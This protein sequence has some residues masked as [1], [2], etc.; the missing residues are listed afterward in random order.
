MGFGDV[1]V[2]GGDGAVRIMSKDSG[3]MG[4]FLFGGI[5]RGLS[6]CSLVSEGRVK[7]IMGVASC[8][9]IV[10]VSGALRWGSKSVKVVP[11]LATETLG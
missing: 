11:V 8:P 2:R 9:V 3:A 1:V 5:I 7:V 10:S 6:F 4:I